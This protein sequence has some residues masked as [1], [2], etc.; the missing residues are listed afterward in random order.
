MI[1]VIKPGL[2][3][4][5]QDLG[6]IGYRKFGV[7]ISGVMDEISSGLAN[8][9][10]NNKKDAAV[11]ITVMGP[12]LLFDEPT[13]FVI[14]GADMSP[15]LQ[16]VPIVNNKIYQTKAGDLLTFG[17][18]ICGCRT[19]IAVKGGFQS[20]KILNSRSYYQG[21]TPQEQLIKGQKLPIFSYQ[22]IA[23]ATAGVISVKNNFFET[24]SIEIL[25][26]PEFD[27][28]STEEQH[29]LLTSLVTLSNKINRMGYQMEEIILPHQKSIITSPV[30]PGTVQLTP[31]GRLIILMKDAQTTGG[32]PRVFQ[33]TKQ[34]KKILLCL[35]TI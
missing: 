3:T 27:L 2:F 18:L 17:K 34:L 22:S 11:E 4:S 35:K 32:Y 29:I 16:D 13:E 14:T 30:I 28:F 15:K 33:L 10:L 23:K 19:Y 21:I 5:I 12:T 9:L 25:K 1:T 20:K 8:A 24:N 26:G 6:R 7:P 31:S